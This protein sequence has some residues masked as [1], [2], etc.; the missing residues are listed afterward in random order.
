MASLRARDVDPCRG[1]R[2]LFVVR[3]TMKVPVQEFYDLSDDKRCICC[4][5]SDSEPGDTLAAWTSAMV[6]GWIHETCM[7]GRA[8]DEAETKAILGSDRTMDAIRAGREQRDAGT[9][10]PDSSVR[11]HAQTV[12]NPTLGW[13]HPGAPGGPPANVDDDRGL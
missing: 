7:F 6:G 12:E 1:P 9:L 4:G 5:E 11:P 13:F 3:T 10:V 2:R 8:G